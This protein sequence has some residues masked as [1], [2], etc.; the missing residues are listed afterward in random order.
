M[1]WFR[2]RLLRIPV[3]PLCAAATVL[4]TALSL[5]AGRSGEAGVLF[6]AVFGVP[7]LVSGVLILIHA[8]GA[9]ARSGNS[10]WRFAAPILAGV[11]FLIC[12]GYAGDA[13]ANW[14]ST[15]PFPPQR[16]VP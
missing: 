12:T 15:G 1:H 11:T 9:A 6:V 10:L 4:F 13:I 7:W 5:A 3:I 16:L 8:H 14:L 2:D